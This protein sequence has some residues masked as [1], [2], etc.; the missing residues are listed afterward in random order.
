MKKYNK[1]TTYILHIIRN[2]VNMASDK[3]DFVNFDEFPGSINEGRDIYEFPLLK[4][5]DSSGKYRMWQ[6][7]IRL[8]KKGK[9]QSEINWNLLKEDQV[10]IKDGYFSDKSL[11]SS[12]HVEIWTETGRMDGVIT[13]SIPTYFDKV[14]FEGQV[15]ERNPFQQALIEARSRWLKRKNDGASEKKSRSSG[16][17]VMHFPMLAKTEKVGLKHITF[18]AYVQP[19]LDGVRCLAFLKKKSG[20]IENVVIYTRT[21]KL[22]PWMK[23][24]KEILYEYLDSLYDEETDQ[25]IFLD[26]ELY[27]HL[28][29]LQDISGQSRN[30]DDLKHIVESA[31]DKKD[32]RK[33]TIESVDKYYIYD[34]FY[35]KELDTDFRDRF[36]QLGEIQRCIEEDDPLEYKYLHKDIK[37]SDLI[38]F[39]P[40]TR[41]ATMKAAR[42]LFKKYTKNKYE[43]IML[44]NIMGGYLANPHKT[45]AAMRSKNLVKVKKV[46][47]D[48]F[49]VVGWKG[50]AKGKDKGAIIWICSTGNRHFNVTPNETY[51]ERKRLYRDAES[52]FDEKYLGRMMTVRYEDKSTAGVPLRAKALGFRDYE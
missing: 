19:K 23:H 43:G 15:N 10:P 32:G 45:S 9:E 8:V 42:K 37:P 4:K 17:N 31:K 29:D 7:F 41:V 11:P 36:A 12:V 27:T 5:V 44:R 28:K 49:E 35:P 13:R 22:F 51:D 16:C 6:I 38:K 20:G 47:T 30:G 24:L 48:E 46:F 14:A 25:S 33:I 52:N 50:G 34:C 3:R 26:G 2:I 18:P 1:T 21:Q 40:T 39:A